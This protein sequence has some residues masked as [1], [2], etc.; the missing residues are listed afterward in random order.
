MENK[1]TILIIE[2]ERSLR[3]ALRDKLTREGF[4]TLE[5]KNGEEG[6][7]VAL[8][9]H[10]ELILLD[11]VMPVMDGMTM[12]KQLRENAWGK[13]VKIIILTNLSDIEKIADSVKNEVY[14]Y[15]VKT[16]WK[17][18][19]VVTKVRERLGE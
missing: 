8:R 18:E 19:D 1:K 13:N 6:L 14:D 10:P 15:L 9:E 12:L 4:S 2:D 11:I 5:A 17:L 7:D 16:D 3:E